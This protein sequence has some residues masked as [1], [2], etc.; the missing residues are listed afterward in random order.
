MSAFATGGRQHLQE[1][2]DEGA[3][4]RCVEAFR[5]CF[6]SFIHSEPRGLSRLITSAAAR[7]RPS[8][9]SF[10]AGAS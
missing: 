1:R 3:R 9:T 5:R 7:P 10:T 2:S 8:L 6:G 4:A